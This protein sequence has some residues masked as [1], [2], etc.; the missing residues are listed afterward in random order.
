MEDPHVLETTWAGHADMLAAASLG[1]H[2][3][4]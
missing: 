4:G 1:D 3:S 2:A